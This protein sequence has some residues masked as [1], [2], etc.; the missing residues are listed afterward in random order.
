M[1]LVSAPGPT[2]AITQ[3]SYDIVVVGGGPVGL[4]TAIELGRRQLAVLLVERD[5][6]VVRYPTAESIDVAS[7]EILRRW[8][9]AHLVARSGFPSDEPR[10]IAFVSRMT[11]H[12]LARFA[13]PSNADRRHTTQGF[14]PEGGVWWPKFWFDP[15]LRQ[16]AG[17]EATMVLRY[18]WHCESFDD[19]SDGVQVRLSSSAYG[20]RLVRARYLVAC[21]GAASPIRRALGIAS[22]RDSADARARWQ[23]AFVRLAGLRERTPHAP[24]VQ[25]YLINPRRM[26]LGSLDG[27]DLWRVTY[28]L[29]GDEQPTAGEVRDTIADALDCPADSVDVLDTREWSGDAVVAESFQSGHVLLAGDSAHRMWPSGGH[30][31][32]TGLGDVANVGWKIEAVV[33]GWAPETLLDTYTAERRPHCERMIRRA[34]RN[35]RADLALLPDPALDDPE[36]TAERDAINRRIVSTRQ[37]EWRSLGAQLGITYADSP[38]IA[39][40]DTPVP[41]SSAGDY[42]PTARPGHRAPHVA[43]ADGSSTLDLFRGRFTLLNLAPAVDSGGLAQALRKRGFP[44]DEEW[45]AAPRARNL[46]RCAVA[47]VRPDGIVAWRGDTPPADPEHLIDQV[48]GHTG[49]QGRRSTPG[50]C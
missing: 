33:R 32:N 45:V 48:T 27:A 39:S 47:L 10:D 38:L 29:S 6:G 50:S 15:A 31:M 8:G 17:E 42:V 40:D 43:L 20:S 16:R 18:R 12:E 49:T 19:G 3:D 13:R 44:V 11:T 9:M 23:G 21:D 24:A 5:D 22:V 14:S 30:G 35:Y 36:R 4:A 7:M 46:Y 37:S 28:P 1:S 26:I 41:A 25:Y 34:W 2:G